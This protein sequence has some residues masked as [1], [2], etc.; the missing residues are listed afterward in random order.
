MQLPARRSYGRCGR[1]RRRGYRGEAGISQQCNVGVKPVPATVAGGV[2]RLM[3]EGKPRFET[4][5]RG[6]AAELR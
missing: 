1:Y 5:V 4:Q 2:L 3:C 6:R